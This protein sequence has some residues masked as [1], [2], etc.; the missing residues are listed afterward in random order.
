MV[1]F[2]YSANVVQDVDLDLVQWCLCSL[3]FMFTCLHHLEATWK[4]NQ[5]R[6]LIQIKAIATK[7]SITSQ[8]Q[9]DFK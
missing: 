8:F 7:I 3:V 5:I 6:D 9:K 4:S 2:Q 1:H